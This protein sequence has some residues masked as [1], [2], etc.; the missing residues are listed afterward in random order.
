MRCGRRCGVV[1]TWA[2]QSEGHGLMR[3]LAH[4]PPAV[5]NT[6]L[7][8]YHILHTGLALR[9]A[10]AVDS[11]ATADVPLSFVAKASNIHEL[12][13]WHGLAPKQPD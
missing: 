2:L 1:D 11:A 6:S 8:I 12:R 7:Q 4:P 5:A 10:P 9:R 3:K 13:Q